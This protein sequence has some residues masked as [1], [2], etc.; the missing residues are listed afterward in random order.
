VSVGATATIRVIDMGN[1]T[2]FT[3]STNNGV[4]TRNYSAEFCGIRLVVFP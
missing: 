4:S 2:S 3:G 1:V